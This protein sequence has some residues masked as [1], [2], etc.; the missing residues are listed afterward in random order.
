ML[1]PTRSAS[2]SSSRQRSSPNLTVVTFIPRVAIAGQIVNLA[3]GVCAIRPRGRGLGWQRGRAGGEWGSD[4][5]PG[6]RLLEAD[7]AP[8][9]LLPDAALREGEAARGV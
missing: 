8:S 1:I 2:S 3:Y 9:G 6:P 4:D 7:R 5:R